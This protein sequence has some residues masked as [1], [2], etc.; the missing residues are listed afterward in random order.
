MPRDK[1][2]DTKTADNRAARSQDRTTKSADSNRVA[3]SQDRAANTLED[4]KTAKLPRSK[5]KADEFKVRAFV[6]FDI[7]IEI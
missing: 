6:D 2:A 3:R 1:S 4:K 7:Y 5:S